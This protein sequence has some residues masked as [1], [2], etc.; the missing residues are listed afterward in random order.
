VDFALEFLRLTIKRVARSDAQ[1][2][3]SLDSFVPLLATSLNSRKGNASSLSL[4]MMTKIIDLPL[5][6]L[7]DLA[8]EGGRGVIRLLDS[9]PN[10]SDPVAQD[11]LRLLARILRAG[12]WFK[13]T[14]MQVMIAVSVFSLKEA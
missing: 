4:K 7:K 11:C 13:P 12:Q 8:A 9:V 5:P 6:S 14:E 3:E 1:T 2:M 10:T